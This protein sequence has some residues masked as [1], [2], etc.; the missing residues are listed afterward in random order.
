VLAVGLTGG[1]ACG[2]TKIRER[3]D[4]H[5]VPTLDAD[6]VVH[7]LFGPGTD[8]TREIAATFGAS[9]IGPDGAVDRKALG[10]VVF[11]D[12]P[13]RKRLEAIV[14]PEVFEAIDEFLK[15]AR[16]ADADVA[17]VDAALMYET[18]SYDRYDRVVVAYCPPEVQRERLVKR[19]G[20][21][22]EQAERRIA[23]Q[24]PVEEK[25]DRADYVIDTSGTMEQTLART[26]TVLEQLKREAKKA[27]S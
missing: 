11:R 9:V 7:R 10:A 15:N 18:G 27:D 13:Q 19:D 26:D 1:I 20:L 6:G 25:R 2:K 22:A 8:V 16:D 24:M 4:A 12:P 14:H 21:T 3:L 5:G 17:V 23:S